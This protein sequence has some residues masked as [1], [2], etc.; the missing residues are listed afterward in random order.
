LS[1]SVVTKTGSAASLK[2]N[3]TLTGSIITNTLL[4]GALSIIHYV[5]L[6]GSIITQ[7][8]LNAGLSL[9]RAL[10]GSIGTK[11]GLSGTLKKAIALSGSI[12]TITRLL[13]DLT[14]TG[15]YFL[16]KA[17][18]DSLLHPG[19]Q[20]DSKIVTCGQAD[21]NIEEVAKL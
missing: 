5:F 12:S 4:T 3:I 17:K 18:I 11:S 14:I 9:N 21:S 7:T 19:R 2:R 10:S 6:A 1:G 15:F 16:I 8:G 13:G 20:I